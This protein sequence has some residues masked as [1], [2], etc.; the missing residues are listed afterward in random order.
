M[1]PTNSNNNNV[2]AQNKLMATML[3]NMQR[4]D[5]SLHFSTDCQM[6]TTNLKSDYYDE[7]SVNQSTQDMN[8]K[9]QW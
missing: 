6:T 9:K 1:T 5:Q 8:I 3:L 2:I 4:V 7:R